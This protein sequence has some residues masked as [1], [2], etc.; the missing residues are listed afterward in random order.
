MTA[1]RRVPKGILRDVLAHIEAL[2]HADRGA[3]LIEYCLIASLIGAVIVVA[4]TQVRSDLQNLPFP[5]L[6]A[7]FTEALS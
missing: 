4:L 6:I 2:R 5:A 1:R 7:A 3:T